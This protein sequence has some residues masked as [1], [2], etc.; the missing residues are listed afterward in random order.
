MRGNSFGKL[1]SFTSFGESHGEYMGVTIDGMPAGILINE[2]DLQAELDKRR[3][4]K[5]KVS[6]SR[7]EADKAQIIS[8]IFESK[9]LG[10]PLTV[11]IK[12]TNQKSEDYSSLKESYRPGHADKTTELKFGIRDYRGGGR[13]SGRET[14]SRVIAGYFAN[15]IIPSIEVNIGISQIASF[16]TSKLTF[17]KLGPLHFLDTS[18]ENEIEAFLLKCKESGESAGGEIKVV[19]KNCPK[20]LGE[21]VF[22]KLKADFAK[23]FLSIGSCISIAFGIGEEFKTKLGSEISTDSKNFGGIEGGI[24]NG[25]EIYITLGF[26][27]PSTIGE[28]ALN[29]RHDPCILPRVVPVVKAMAQVVIADHYLRQNAYQIKRPH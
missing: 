21:P 28:K 24:S 14:V 10:T 3:P 22:D 1:F 7:N 17:D 29:G 15:L 6:T 11:I 5:L 2:E 18:M 9:T 19:I 8:G 20:G 12:N 26:K 23:A 27:A 25:E 16:K 4:G 13:A